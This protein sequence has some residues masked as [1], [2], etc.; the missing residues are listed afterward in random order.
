VPLMA[1]VY[2]TC[3]DYFAGATLPK[4]SVAP[5]GETIVPANLEV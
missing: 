4:G 2:R 3:R 1:L 5:G